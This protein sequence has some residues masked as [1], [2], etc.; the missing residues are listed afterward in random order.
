MLMTR[1]VLWHPYH[2]MQTGLDDK[3]SVGKAQASLPQCKVETK[4]EQEQ[5][6]AHLTYMC[7]ST[8]L[9]P[10]DKP[11]LIDVQDTTVGLGEQTGLEGLLAYAHTQH[12]TVNITSAYSTL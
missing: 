1:S 7:T 5:H 2:G 11:H 10:A 4:S 6:D 12:T 8:R 3:R 9:L